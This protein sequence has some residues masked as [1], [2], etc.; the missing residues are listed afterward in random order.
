MKRRRPGATETFSVSVDRET[1]KRLKALAEAKH[2]GNVS[3]LITELSIEGERQAAFERAWDWYGGAEPTAAE[4]AA[5]R[6]EW[7]E[8][9]NHARKAKK[10]KGRTA[11]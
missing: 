10:P 11:A 8:G 1:K 4:S 9:W 5:I 7:A 2:R 3:A 6:R